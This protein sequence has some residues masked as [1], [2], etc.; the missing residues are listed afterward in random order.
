M[1]HAEA[2]SLFTAYF[3]GTLSREQTRAL[4]V[5]FKDCEACRSRIRLEKA[6]GDRKLRLDDN[7]LASPQ[8]QNQIAKNRD[9]LIKILLLFALAWAVYKYKT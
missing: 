5:H 7:S 4:H 6:M 2:Q 8:V 1:E 3:N 9:L